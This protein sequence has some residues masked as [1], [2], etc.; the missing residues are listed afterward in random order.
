MALHWQY[1]A[2]RDGFLLGGYIAEGDENAYRAP[3]K[4]LE[5]PNVKGEPRVQVARLVRKHEA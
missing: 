2:R 3:E 4:R 5:P 1:G